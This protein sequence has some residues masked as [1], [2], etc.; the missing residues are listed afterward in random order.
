MFT[1]KSI[2]SVLLLLISTTSFAA[3]PFV[4]GELLVQLSTN[5]WLRHGVGSTA[6]QVSVENL[7]I[8]CRLGVI[9]PGLMSFYGR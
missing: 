9:A 2:L 7:A 1:I 8:H 6:T 5:D 4:K 3:G